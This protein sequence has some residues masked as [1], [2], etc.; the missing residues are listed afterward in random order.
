MISYRRMLAVSLL[1]VVLI[2]Q[3]MAA[4]SQNVIR[5]EQN[6]QEKYYPDPGAMVVDLVV[7]RPAGFVATL[8]GT[9]IFIVSLPF[10]AL[11]GNTGDAWESLVVSPA[12]Y[13]FTRPLGEFPD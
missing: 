8:G 12:V 5:Q 1:A 9:V 4:L 10:S 11:G 2:M 13:T 6:L 7:A 3:P